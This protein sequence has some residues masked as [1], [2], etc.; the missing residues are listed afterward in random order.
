MTPDDTPGLADVPQLIRLGL[1][2]QAITVVQEIRRNHP[3][4]AY[5][6]FLLSVCYFEKLWWSVG[7]QHALTTFQLDPTYRRSPR[8]A[9]ALI[10]SLGSDSFWEKGGAFLRIEMPDISD[11][12]LAEAA[13][14]DR[15]PRARIRAAQ[16]L[17]VPM[18]PPAP[19]GR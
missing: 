19:R 1:H 16:I 18:R 2:D 7:L 10:H 5:A 13:E 15:R 9:R 3:R 4:S 12:Y 6:S 11:A 8:L 14:S 17:S